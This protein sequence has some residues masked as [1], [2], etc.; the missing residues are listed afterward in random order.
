MILGSDLNL[1]FTSY[2]ENFYFVIDSLFNMH[3][4][5]EAAK[6]IFFYLYERINPDGTI[7]GLMN[8][9]GNVIE[10]SSPSDLWYLIKALQK[11]KNKE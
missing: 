7:N 5:K 11:R 1:D 6:L 2:D 8:E 3:F 9:N 10:L 4:G